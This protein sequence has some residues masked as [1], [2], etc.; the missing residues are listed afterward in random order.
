MISSHEEDFVSLIKN[1]SGLEGEQIGY[2][3]FKSYS[4]DQIDLDTNC[5][6]ETD[7]K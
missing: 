1:K 6:V 5:R 3:H 4:K 7:E 2:I